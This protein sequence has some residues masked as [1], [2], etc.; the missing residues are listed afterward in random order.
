MPNPTWACCAEPPPCPTCPDS[1]EFE[2]SYVFDGFTFQFSFDR[3]YGS[4]RPCIYEGGGFNQSFYQDS[5][6]INVTVTQI[7]Q[8]VLTRQGTEGNCCYVACGTFEVEWEITEDVYYGC[9]QP[10]NTPSSTPAVACSNNQTITGVEAVPYVYRIDCVELPVDG[11]PEDS[12]R[13]V[14]RHIIELCGVQVATSHAKA[15]ADCQYDPPN[16]DCGYEPAG[17]LY[18]AGMRFTW[19]TPLIDLAN[20]VPG[21]EN[22]MGGPYSAQC[23]VGPVGPACNPDEDCDAVTTY[24]EICG[25]FAVTELPGGCTPTGC[26]LTGL[27]CANPSFQRFPTLPAC[28]DGCAYPTLPKDLTG[29]ICPCGQWTLECSCIR[30]DA[31]WTATYPNYV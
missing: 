3:S 22:A 20:I 2:S 15:F 21:M 4:C 28:L 11:C 14:W 10:P 1:C 7:G 5:Y 17:A 16:F 29:N 19:W 24:A 8:N 25:P 31:G 27:A 6:A 13:P 23:A 9:C 26:Q 12:K 18:M 30:H